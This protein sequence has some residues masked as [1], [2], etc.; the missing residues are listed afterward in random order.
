MPELRSRRE[1][2]TLSAE[3][4]PIQGDHLFQVIPTT[5][6]DGPEKVATFRPE[7]AVAF[8]RNQ[9]PPSRRNRWPLSPGK[10]I[11]EAKKAPEPPRI[12]HERDAL[13]KLLA[14][15]LEVIDLLVLDPRDMA[16]LRRS[17]EVSAIID[18]YVQAG[19]ALFAF[20]TETAEY[21][22]VVGGPLTG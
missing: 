21:R 8:R 6:S 15:H 20:G 17:R 10:R 22:G 13:R 1:S 14:Q 19:G 16:Q 7:R 4:I 9:W 18:R 12:P 11:E 3:P 2:S 5:H